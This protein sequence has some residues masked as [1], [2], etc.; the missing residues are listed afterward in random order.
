[1]C[2]C[3]NIPAPT[4]TIFDSI[5]NIEEILA[6]KFFGLL[7]I[8]RDNKNIRPRPSAYRL[9]DSIG[10]SFRRDQKPQTKATLLVRRNVAAQI[11]LTFE[12]AGISVFTDSLTCDSIEPIYI[13]SFAARQKEKASNP[14]GNT[15]FYGIFCTP[16]R[17]F[18]V[19]YL[20]EIGVFFQH[21]LTLFH[22]FIQATGIEKTAIIMMGKSTAAI[23][24]YLFETYSDVMPKKKFH[25]DSFARIFE[26]T[27]LPVYFIPIGETGSQILRCMLIPNYREAAAKAILLKG[28][29]PPYK[30]L[31][32][33]DTIHIHPPHYPVVIAIDMEVK[34]IDIALENAQKSGF[35]RIVV[36]ALQE[37]IPF[38]QNHYREKEIDFMVINLNGFKNALEYD[39]SLCR[40]SVKPFIT[41]DGRYLDVTDFTSDRKIGK[42]SRP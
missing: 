2:W 20:D 12:M 11:L 31:P 41:K 38:L 18:I 37:Q 14:F 23:G 7:S 25:T 10:Y 42:Q 15:R 16:Q 30:E 21:E 26:T 35:K 22:N 3:K 9:L 33:T 8:S 1:M 19:Y 32:D 24:A 28:Y 17:A 39:I 13:A 34:R 5:C 40:P 6:L 27:I 29:Q 4:D 36:Y